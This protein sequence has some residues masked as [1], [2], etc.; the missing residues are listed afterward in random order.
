MCRNTLVALDAETTDSHWS[1]QVQHDCT[2]DQKQENSDQFTFNVNGLKI[3]AIPSGPTATIF[4]KR[5]L[6]F[7]F[8]LL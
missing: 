6:S 8:S 2:Y 7:R 1:R 5:T 4:S 3:T